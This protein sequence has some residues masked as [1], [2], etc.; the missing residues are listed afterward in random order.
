[1]ADGSAGKPRLQ[2]VQHG[3][4]GD[5]AG[6]AHIARRDL[7]DWRGSSGRGA[8]ATACR[9][10]GS[11]HAGPAGR[12]NRPRLRRL[13]QDQRC[14]AEQ[15]AQQNL[16]A[17]IAANVIE[18]APDHVRRCAPGAIAPVRPSSV[19][20]T[21]LGAPVVPE[22]NSTH[23]VLRAAQSASPGRAAGA[24]V[25]SARRPP[26][27]PIVAHHRVDAGA[28][29]HGGQMLGFTSGGQI[30]I[31]AATPSS[32]ISASAANSWL[33]GAHQHIARPPGRRPAR[34][35]R[36]A[37]ATPCR[38]PDQRGIAAGDRG[39]QAFRPRRHLDRISRSRPWSRGNRHL[40]TR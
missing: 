21:I 29:D 23:S 33:G 19:C 9:S 4:V 17:A 14:M 30:T 8:N 24:A 26:P 40:R 16:Q 6:Q 35:P 22:V 1:M 32:S 39:A 13:R 25:R 37:S 27:A 11:R 28:V 20:A 36:S 18:G 38:A 31:R 2:A 34:R 10:D 12:G 7:R 3:L 15:G 5:L